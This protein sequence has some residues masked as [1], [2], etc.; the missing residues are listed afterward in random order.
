MANNLLLSLLVLVGLATTA[1]ANPVKLAT[2]GDLPADLVIDLR[3]G[4]FRTGSIELQIS[5]LAG[6]EPN[7]VSG[8]SPKFV[9]GRY[10]RKI[11]TLLVEEQGCGMGTRAIPLTCARAHLSR[12]SAWQAESRG[13]FADAQRHL[14]SA[15]AADPSYQ[16]AARDLARVELRLGNRSAAALALQPLSRSPI[17]SYVEL[18]F[19]PMLAPL[20]VEQPWAKLRSAVPGK[21]QIGGIR[22]PLIARSTTHELLAILREAPFGDGDYHRADR[23]RRDVELVIVDRRGAIVAIASLLDRAPLEMTWSYDDLRDRADGIAVRIDAA[24]LVLRDLGFEPLDAEI[25]R[26]STKPNGTNAARFPGAKLGIAEISGVMRL[27]QK[28]STLAERRIY[29]CPTFHCEY[30][31]TLMWAAWVPSLKL[32]L[33]TWH[34]SGAEHQDRVNTLEVWQIT[35]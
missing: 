9:S 30:S 15:L 3:D 29:P 34:S 11:H 20:L 6:V 23:D 12:A 2:G 32:V 21:A 8:C 16:R 1:R 28:N 5:E 14:R 22:S 17:S 18:A 7:P 19:D 25:S 10:D 33:V 24:N 26:F 4:V 27:L 35:P 13:E 31:P